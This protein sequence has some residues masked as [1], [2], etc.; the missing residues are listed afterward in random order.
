MINIKLND[1]F[2]NGEQME[3]QAGLVMYEERSID[4][5]FYTRNIDIVQPHFSVPLIFVF[6]NKVSGTGGL[7]PK[8]W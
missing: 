6:S 2:S 8:A 7:I 4:D 1:V 5:Y 3:L